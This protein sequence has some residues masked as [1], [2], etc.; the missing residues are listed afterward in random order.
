[1]ASK[2]FGVR[3]EGVK[4]TYFISISYTFYAVNDDRNKVTASH[5]GHIDGLSSRVQKH[6]IQLISE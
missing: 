1:M 3:E 4:T 2:K 5:V 6:C